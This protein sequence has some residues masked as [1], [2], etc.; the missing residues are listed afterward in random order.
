MRRVE[1]RFFG[2]VQGVGFR[3]T[4]QK[5][6]I[7]L[8]IKGYVR[9]ELDGSVFAEMEGSSDAI[10]TCVGELTDRFLVS[11]VEILFLEKMADFTTFSITF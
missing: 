3:Y 11:K 9:N 4:T 8:D 6:S 7:A 2:E 5:V 1:V 10:F